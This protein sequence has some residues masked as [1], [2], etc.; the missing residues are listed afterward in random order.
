MQVSGISGSNE[1]LFGSVGVSESNLGRDSFMRLLVTQLKN[2]DP[3]EPSKNEEM[4]AQLAQFSSLE[5]MEELN[6]NIVGLA[7]LE[8][9]N[10][11]MS[12]LT[13]SSVLID[14]TVKYLDPDT[15]SE[16]WGPV[17]SVKIE[18]GLAILHIS[19]KDVP[20]ANVIEIGPEPVDSSEA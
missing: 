11:L 7:V 2:Q 15:N 20:L 19:G 16:T 8:Q 10:A 12:Q 4:L 18:E 5:Q 3:L 17:A 1:S 9:S 14:K 6:D 13:N